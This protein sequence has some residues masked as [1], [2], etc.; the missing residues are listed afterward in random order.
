MED[1]IVL[2]RFNRK[3]IDDLIDVFELSIKRTCSKDYT[4]EQIIAWVS[5]A[6][7][8]KW[9]SIFESHYSLVAF[10][11]ERPVGFGDINEYGY[12]NM[13]YV[14]PK[15]QRK[16][17]ATVICDR[18]EKHVQKDIL[19]DVSYTAKNFFLNRGYKVIKEQTVYRKGI[20]INNFKMSKSM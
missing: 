17:I 3:Y 7:R 6:D 12:L 11:E 10:L 5:G 15:Y 2:K 8:D 9:I 19:V 16:G 13:L 20:A 14:H 18:L 4:K 1:K